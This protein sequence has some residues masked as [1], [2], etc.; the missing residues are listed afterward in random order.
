MDQPASLPLEIVEN[1]IEYVQRKKD[2]GSCCLLC[3]ELLPRS[4]K[5]LFA[6]ITLVSHEDILTLRS[7]LLR[8]SHLIQFISHLGIL[9]IEM[10][11]FNT[12]QG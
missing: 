6:V 8:S 5:H 2:T 11:F 4:R 10:Y 9:D 7:H 12:E 1:I 3:R